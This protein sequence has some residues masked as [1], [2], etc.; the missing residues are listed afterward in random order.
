M[1]C[2]K[3]YSLLLA[4]I[5]YDPTTSSNSQANWF[6]TILPVLKVSFGFV[7]W[8]AFEACGIVSWVFIFS[9]LVG[10]I[11]GIILRLP[12]VSVMTLLH[13]SHLQIPHSAETE[14]SLF[15][16]QSLVAPTQP[17]LMMFLLPGMPFLS[18]SSS[19]QIL[20]IL[21]SCSFQNKDL[22]CKD[23]GRKEMRSTDLARV[24]MYLVSF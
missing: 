11:F 24:F 6:H 2:P 8:T 12:E 10:F 19:A 18:H 20:L 22:T 3:Q 15:L 17:S 5:A 14:S 4:E 23:R 1:V 7:F 21:D 16:M 9:W 13:Y